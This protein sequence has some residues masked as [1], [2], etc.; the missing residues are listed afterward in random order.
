MNEALEIKQLS[1]VAAPAAKL[2]F[3][4]FVAPKVKHLKA[5]WKRTKAIQD[6][7]FENKFRSYLE[8]RYKS[9]SVMNVLAFRNQ[10]RLLKDIYLPLTV[11]SSL[12]ADRDKVQYTIDAYN[13]DFLPS[14]KKILITDTAGMGKSTLT[15]LMFLSAIERQA[16]IPVLIEL[17]RL[18]AKK[19]VLDEI[20]STLKIL[21]TEMDRDF[22]VDLIARGDFIFFLDG[23]DEISE[24]D[25]A[26]VTFDLKKFIDDAG[27]NLFLLTSRPEATLASFGGFRE[28][29]IQSLDRDEA[30]QLIRKY[31]HGGEV[32]KALIEKLN[33][34]NFQNISEFLENPLLVSLLFTAFEYKKTIPLKKHLF[35]RQVYDAI[36]EAHDLSKGDYYIRE[37]FSGL[38]ID[39]FHTI[40]RCMA[41]ICLK[42]DKIEFSKDELLAVIMQASAH[43]EVISFEGSHF[44][45]DL[46]TTVPLFVRDGLLYRWAH[47]SLYEYFCAQFI[48]LDSKGSQLNILL[49]MMRK[50]NVNSYFNIIDLY[51]YIDF[52]TFRN[53]L[54]P[55]VVRDFVSFCETSYSAFSNISESEITRRQEL[56]FIANCV[57]V[58]VNEDTWDGE[59]GA[60]NEYMG[61]P[62]IKESIAFEVADIANLDESE[63]YGMRLYGDRSAYGNGLGDYFMLHGDE[64]IN[65]MIF[66]RY[67]AKNRV[68]GLFRNPVQEEFIESLNISI[69]INENKLY[70]V[71]DDPSNK[72]ND[73]DNFS[74]VTDLMEVYSRNEIIF[75]KRGALAFLEEV[76][77][78]D[79]DSNK[80]FLKL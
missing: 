80:N 44:L 61:S 41:F 25:K 5:S 78:S 71:D 63:S 9:Y 47:K 52:K 49:S 18:S 43:C 24:K 8:S 28:F 30:F 75:S 53:Q 77:S 3:D 48:H 34:A 15:K 10:Q 20:L 35:Y 33:E 46:V 42:Q 79:E 65:S 23:Y 60:S 64:K 62:H 21:D 11:S 13:H 29:E 59:E 76:D 45:R 51:S 31:D 26:D 7:F 54:L 68:P 39:E 73:L 70:R 72:L 4:T 50:P 1:V 36:F 40:L 69:N 67:I 74:S 2:L 22:V 32:S 57:V 17:R 58:K 55:I 6:H 37:K 16:G 14:L 56:S 12:V 27:E 66:I 38:S 19:S